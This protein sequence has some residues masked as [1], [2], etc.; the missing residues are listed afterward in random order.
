MARKM[1]TVK[2]GVIGLGP[3]SPAQI[4][5]TKDAGQAVITAICDCQ[6]DKIAGSLKLM[7][8]RGLTRPKTYTDYRALLADKEVEAVLV[9]SSWNSHLPIARDAMLAG[10]YV[11][12]EVGG[13]S[14]MDQLWE[15]VRTS[16]R[17]RIPCMMLENCC[18][19]RDEMM[20]MSLVRQGYFGELIYCECG[21][22]HNLSG[23]ACAIERNHERSLHN[24]RRNGDLYPTHGLGPV[25]KIL[26]INRGNRFISLTS[27]ATKARG[28][29]AA[30]EKKD[31]AGAGGHR[32]FN[33]GD[34]ITTVIRCANGE[35]IT[36]VHGV[37]L[38]R[39][40]SRDCRVQGTKGI[41]LENANGLF[42][43]GLTQ[44]EFVDAKGKTYTQEKWDEVKSYYEKHDHPLWKAFRDNVTGGHGGMD[45]LVLQA[46]FDAV[47]NRA[48]T[49]I[50]VYDCAAWMCVTCLSEDSIAMGCAPV[51]VPDFTNGKWINREPERATPW[52]LST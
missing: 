38:P 5:G 13:A 40:Y 37:S 49:P 22:E 18:Y 47:R 11:A 4:I 51:A 30:A 44:T 2:V 26:G 43:E 35:V 52:A 27:T 34:I 16:E 7:K 9:P 25:S 17:T 12:F 31:W 8:E 29:A 46:F 32:V 10:K 19:G 14:S 33:K 20:V 6:K 50:D 15:L 21:Y 28:F 1:K 42:I 48:P 36:M 23:M 45:T 39:P 24:L 41:W 3:R